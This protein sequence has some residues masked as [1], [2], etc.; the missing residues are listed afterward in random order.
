MRNL[1][2]II[3]REYLARVRNK[4][5]V[6]MTFL[7]PIIMVCMIVLVAY[8]SNLN[9]DDSKI[10]AIHDENNTFYKEFPSTDNITYL[11]YSSLPIEVALDSIEKKDYYGLLFFPKSED[12]QYLSNHVE[13]F[14]NKAPGISFISDI[15]G[16]ISTVLTNKELQQRGV[17]VNEINNSKTNVNLQIEN[18]SGEETSKLS[19][20]VKMFFGGAAGYLLM[21]FIIIYGNMVM[22]SVIEEKTNRIIEVI[23]SSV[24]PMQLM[25]G[26][27]L[28]TSFAGI[29]QFAIW[30][31]FGGI[32]LF[33]VTTVFGIDL[34]ASAPVSPTQ[35]DAGSQEEIQKIILD[36]LNLPLAKLIFC[37]LI[38]FI[39]GYFLYSSVYAAIG[40]AVD[41]ETDTQQ[42]MFPI[43][44]PLMLGIYVG[45]FSVISDPHGV[46]STVFSYIPLTSP[47]VMLM[48]IPFGV[49]W[50]E[51]LLSMAILVLS[52]FVLV[53][54]AA[55]IYRVGILM[56]GKKPTYKELYRWMKY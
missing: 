39:G 44:V 35:M 46:V 20:Y 19:N 48:R 22:R 36:I 34:Q 38:Y 52:I 47:V 42:F 29:T 55:K 18:F 41:N 56:Y 3:L 6:I 4:T 37:F 23:I 11:D 51:I 25:I 33:T 54:V 32:L 31:F 14:A 12:N 13:F 8:L 53:W 21:M 10:I 17:D 49:A 45:F 24:K 28:G 26:K 1:K 43:I 16:K 40:A 7:S 50:W 5:F 2:L 30:I 9:S 15:E 27:I